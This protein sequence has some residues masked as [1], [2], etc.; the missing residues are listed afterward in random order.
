M[1]VDIS[2]SLHCK[3]ENDSDGCRPIWYSNKAE[4]ANQADH[5]DF[6]LKKN[7]LASKPYSAGIVDVC[8]RQIL[9]TKHDPR[10]VR[11]KIF[12]MAVDP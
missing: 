3:S 1:S 6:K 4:R 12:L 9:T 8:R 2:R 10:T 5:D 7:L 11:V